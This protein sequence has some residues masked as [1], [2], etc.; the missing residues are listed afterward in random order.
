M[1]K[2]IKIQ[3]NSFLRW[4]GSKK[5]LLSEIGMHLP[6]KY[7]NYHEPFLGSGAL[8][9]NLDKKEN[10]FLSDSN[11]KLINTYIQI[12]ENV[13]EVIAQLKKY[14][15]N[16]AFYYFIRSN[17][18]KSLVEDAAQ[19][20]YLNRTC[21]NGLYRVNK[22]DH[23]NVPYGKRPNVDFVTEDLLKAVSD[24]LKNVSINA[25]D[26]E[27]SLSNIKKNDLVFIDPPYI[28]SHNENGFI[29]YNQ[30]I[31]TWADQLR[32]HRYI[33]Q[34]MDKDAY[35]I[36][37]NAAHESIR[38]L[39]SDICTPHELRRI[40]KI[41]GKNSYR[42]MVKEFLFTNTERSPY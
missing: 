5:A 12:R 36:L 29:E 32:L 41:G 7:S 30:K 20:I 24:S 1:K 10:C 8:F 26:F 17:V 9:F 42:G 18:S 6:E 39:Y 11:Q 21:F 31:F 23:F 19:F 38:D 13:Y 28:V 4:A 3:P 16:E 22:N 37:S 14:H 35:F 40:S 27:E 33:K 15:N 25:Y 2:D 34:V